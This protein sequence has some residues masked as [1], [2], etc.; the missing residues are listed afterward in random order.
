MSMAFTSVWKVFP[1][2]LYYPFPAPPSSSWICLRGHFF[3]NH[4]QPTKMNHSPFSTSHSSAVI[5]QL[6]QI[7]LVSDSVPFPSGLSLPSPP[8]PICELPSGCGPILLVLAP[9]ATRP[10][11]W[12][13]MQNKGEWVALL[14]Q[15]CTLS[16]VA[17]LAFP[18]ACKSAQ[19]PLKTTHSKR[20]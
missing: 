18:S 12:T 8:L 4:Y 17:H 6:L 3:G 5:S 1:T 16:S 2:L 20:F 15:S 13:E 10:V 19:V 14:H 9:W 7:T 11:S